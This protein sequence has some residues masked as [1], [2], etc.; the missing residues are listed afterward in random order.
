[1]KRSLIVGIS[2]A[3]LCLTQTTCA[4]TSLVAVK[5][6]GTFHLNRSKLNSVRFRGSTGQPGSDLFPAEGAY[7][8]SGLSREQYTKLKKKEADEIRK[9]DFGSWGPRFKRSDAPDGD[10]MVI[11]SLWTNGFNAQPRQSGGQPGKPIFGPVAQLA[12]F[13]RFHTPAFLLGYML[14]H[15]ILAASAL[16]RTPVLV[17]KKVPATILRASLATSSP[18]SVMSLLR[19]QG[20]KSLVAV[21]LTPAMHSVLEFINRR[22]LWSRRRVVIS[23]A[24]SSFCSLGLWAILLSLVRSIS[25]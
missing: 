19:T 24:G 25:V 9:M 20:I 18:L 13:L 3:L 15:S 8:P 2:T 21:L 16:Y 11:P 23:A 6:T 5:Q 10:W 1:M 7:I 17:Y 14:I 12:S 22:R 4:Y